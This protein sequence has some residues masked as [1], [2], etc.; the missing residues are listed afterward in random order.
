VDAELARRV[1]GEAGLLALIEMLTDRV[2]SKEDRVALRWLAAITPETPSGEALADLMTPDTPAY[3]RRLAA[4]RLLESE[5]R[6]AA[7]AVFRE[8]A[9]R[10]PAEAPASAQALLEA[11]ERA[12]L[13]WGLLR[14]M[15]LMAN[16][17][18]APQA[19]AALLQMGDEAVALPAALHLLAT[20]HTELYTDPEPLWAV[21]ESLIENTRT[22]EVGLALRPG[23]SQRAKACEALLEAGR[24]E[25]TM[26]L[27]QYLAY[28]CHDEASQDACRR[29]L[30]LKE[31]QRVVPL[32][33]QVAHLAAP[34]LRYQACLALA[35][36]DLATPQDGAQVP[37]RGELKAA[38][39]SE[40]TRAYHA[41]LH[42]FCQAGLGA[43]EALQPG[44]SVTQA[45]QALG[46]LG[47]KCLAE[48]SI[49]LDQTDEWETL[50]DSPWSAASVNVALFDLRTGRVGRAKRR[51]VGLLRE[52]G[53]SLPLP[54]RLLALTALGRIV[55]PETTALLT[56]A[57]SDEESFVRW[58][59]VCALER[60]G[61]RAAVQPLLA[62]LSDE[63]R[64]VRWSA[65]SALG[66]LGDRAAV[67]PL[68]AALSDE[69]SDV[70]SSA[71]SALGR[72]GDRAAVPP[73]LAAL[74]SEESDVRRFAAEALGSLGD[75]AAVQPLLAALSD[76]DS[77][78]RSSAA[79][80]LGGAG[81]PGGGA[82]P[83]RGPE[84]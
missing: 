80:A 78:V 27:L 57:L 11:G 52:V 1:L 77:D 82:T 51:L 67:Q 40:R 44:D 53:F 33:T 58:S 8:L 45:A 12:H 30:T 50:V 36:A 75:P 20:R 74:S 21:T 22:R 73:L 62:A 59:A 17:G 48:P 9:Q 42:S 3:I 56:Q 76:E 61:D 83:A 28:E 65:A 70:R 71:A 6:T 55:G 24:I 43:L 37:G 14:D 49:A 54:V 10:E 72:L 31:A 32:L 84:R 29:L 47:L 18:N 60:L 16:D 68:L 4:T 79:E 41:A 13:D 64:F 23:Y 19:I 69:D 63:D 5:Q 38:I 35:L 46:R 34:S 25:E 26:P 7:I 39:L 81:R 66:S 2:E 15:A